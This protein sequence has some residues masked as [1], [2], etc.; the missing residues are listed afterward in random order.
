MVTRCSSLLSLL[1]AATLATG[2]AG[3]SDFMTEVRSTPSASL[4]ERAHVVFLRPARDNYLTNFAILDENGVWIGDSVAESYFEADVAPGRHTFIGW[5]RGTAPLE[6]TLLA[7]RVYSVKVTSR[8]R[9]GLPTA[10]LSAMSARRDDV[11]ALHTT[12]AGMRHLEPQASGVAYVARRAEAA[13]M[14]VASARALWDALSA[15]SRQLRT[16]GPSDGEV[17]TETPD[18]TTQADVAALGQDTRDVVAR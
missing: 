10:T 15:E 13:A 18:I 7:G 16:L 11:A 12:L 2:C 14:R 17:V 9:A 6:A 3:A 1:A 5:S 8:L 4:A